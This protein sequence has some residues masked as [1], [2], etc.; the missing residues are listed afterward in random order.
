MHELSLCSAIVDTVNDR[1]SGRPVR[2]VR[3]RVGH[4]RQVVPDTM[5]FCWEMVTD[6]TPLS[7]CELEIE[8]VPAVVS[9]RSCGA[10]T[11]LPDPILL[12]AE[13]DGADVELVAG[14]ELLIESIDVAAMTG[15]EGAP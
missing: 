11:T 7:P 2:R 12:C 5:R 13:C 10:R 14:D 1:A 9:C 4:Y 6:G 8:E 15:P 3:I